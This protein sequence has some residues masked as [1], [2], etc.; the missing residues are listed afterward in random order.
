MDHVGGQIKNIFHIF[1]VQTIK[2]FDIGQAN[3]GNPLISIKRMSNFYDHF[4]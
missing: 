2:S 1:S 4:L 3:K